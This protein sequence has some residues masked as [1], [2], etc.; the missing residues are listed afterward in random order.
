[1]QAIW[2]H[3]T[4]CTPRLFSW[5]SLELVTDILFVS[6]TQSIHCS[7][8]S[9][10]SVSPSLLEAQDLKTNPDVSWHQPYCH[11]RKLTIRTIISHTHRSTRVLYVCY[12]MC[13]MKPDSPWASLF[14]SQI[15]FTAAR[16]SVS[17]R[18]AERSENAQLTAS[19]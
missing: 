8:I 15:F 2:R 19:I 13:V 6:S 9:I 5:P 3:Y 17:L 10:H 7:S 18:E 16:P 1:M 12:L 11:Y 14:F 4:R